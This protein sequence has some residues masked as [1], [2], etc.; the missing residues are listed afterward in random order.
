MRDRKASY[1]ITHDKV[2]LYEKVVG[3]LG[4]AYKEIGDLSKKKPN[5]AINTFKLEFI[6]QTLTLANGLLGDKYRPFP[7]FQTFD[8][9]TVPTTS[10][11]VLV[12][13]HYRHAMTKFHYDHTNKDLLDTDWNFNDDDSEDEPSE[14]EA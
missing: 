1:G 8:T 4:I 2:A 14:E 13:S 7:H 5:D 3:Q 10:D 12:L 9:A 11:A 6:N